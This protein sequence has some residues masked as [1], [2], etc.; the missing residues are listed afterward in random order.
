MTL[1]VSA[2]ALRSYDQ[3]PRAWWLKYHARVPE[4]A[5]PTYLA[6]GSAVDA[7]VQAHQAPGTTPPDLL[8]ARDAAVFGRL[9]PLLPAPATHAIQFK[10]HLAP[11]VAGGRWV[12]TGAADLR[13]PGVVRDVK[14]T[15]DRGV[16]RGSSRDEPPRALTADT[17]AADVQ[18]QLYA[19]CEFQLDPML[20]VCQA[21]WLYGSKTAAQAWSVRCAFTRAATEA[22]FA[23]YVVPRAEA[24]VA[25]AAAAGG[26]LDA[27]AAGDSACARC[28]VKLSCPSPYEG[29]QTQ[30]ASTMTFDLKKLKQATAGLGA[31]VAPLDQALAVSTAAAAD[32]NRPRSLEDRVLTLEA[33]VATLEAQ[34]EAVKP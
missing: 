12:I 20:A 23:S 24:M 31:A 11:A 3:C 29:R 5:R 34:A 6:R 28:Y 27:P 13:R 32:I 14:T 2:S 15:S 4:D 22:W 16:N 10:Y 1:K 26:V 18:A 25:L 33:R 21:E 19:W 7:A 9:R 8:D 30:E 17:L